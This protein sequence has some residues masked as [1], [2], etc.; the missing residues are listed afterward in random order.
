MIIDDGSTDDTEELVGKWMCDKEIN[1]NYFK[2]DNGGK[3]SAINFALD[4]I[5]TRYW[6]CLDSDDT[7]ANNAIELSIKE[8][9]VIKDDSR[10]CGILALRNYPNGEIFGGKRIP[11]KI[12]ETTVLEVIDKYRIRSEFVQLYKT[13]ITSEYRFPNILGEKFLPPEYL[14]NEINK[15]YKFK[16]SQSTFC[17]CEYLPD[18][19]SKNKINII[20]KNP[21]GYTLIVR[22][23][24][25]M[26]KGFI[27]KSKR[28]LKYI[29]GCILSGDKR[30]IRNSPNK[31]MTIFYYPLGWLV[32]ILRFYFR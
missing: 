23:A 8:L 18:G 25:K 31:L 4:R 14:A 15:K 6:L 26:S 22:Q 28:C 7:L 17:Y 11:I 32:Y 30:C 27:P 10:Y 1:I 21:K 9:E 3:A 29:S 13:L 24:F 16:V 2:K 5:E 20:K 19:L 12:E